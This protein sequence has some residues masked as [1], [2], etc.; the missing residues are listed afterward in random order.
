MAEPGPSCKMWLREDEFWAVKTL[1]PVGPKRK[2]K[3]PR[4]EGNLLCDSGGT[5]DQERGLQ[6]GSQQPINHMSK[7]KTGLCQML[8]DTATPQGRSTFSCLN[9]FKFGHTTCFDQ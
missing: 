8:S 1:R 7:R 3:R 9:Y 5:A 4:V 2:P 6:E